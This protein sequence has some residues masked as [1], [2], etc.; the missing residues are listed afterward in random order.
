[1]GGQPIVQAMLLAAILVGFFAVVGSIA[2]RVAPE[3]VE[4]L[5]LGRVV[6]RVPLRDIEEVHRRGAFVHESW[7]GL[8][9]WKAVTLRRS[10]GLF[11]NVIVT[12]DDPDR[13]IADLERALEAAR[14]AGP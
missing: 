12:P 7:S 2:C 8:C 6:R 13:F 14:G 11:R 9:F 4:V 10:R 5:I 3:A 1:V